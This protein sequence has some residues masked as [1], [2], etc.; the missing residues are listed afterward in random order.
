MSN[1]K[2]TKQMEEE[3]D[4]F[5]EIYIHCYETKNIAMLKSISKPEFLYKL[6]KTVVLHPRYFSDKQYRTNTWELISIDGAVYTVRKNCVYQ[7]VRLG[8]IKK[9]KIAN[10]YSETWKVS[11]AN[12]K[13]CIIDIKEETEL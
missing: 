5:D 3:L 12:N 9:V 10:D 8:A 7:L 1:V 2:L 4:R 6:S 11:Y 13:T